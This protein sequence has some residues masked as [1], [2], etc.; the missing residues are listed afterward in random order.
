VYK[1][2]VLS[3]VPVYDFWDIDK[4]AD[5]MISVAASDALRH[6]LTSNVRREYQRMS[7]EKVAERCLALY[8][9]VPRKV[10]A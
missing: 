4:L 2:Q 1:R 3:S 8:R 9:S 5:Q 6:E 10:A 7:W